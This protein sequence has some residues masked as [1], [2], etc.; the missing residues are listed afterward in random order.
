MNKLLIIL[1]AGLLCVACATTEKITDAAS[2]EWTYYDANGNKKAEA[3]FH[4]DGSRKTETLYWP[5]GNKKTR[6]YYESDGV[7]KNMEWTYWESNGNPKTFIWYNRR[8]TLQNPTGMIKVCYKHNGKPSEKCTLEKHGCNLKSNTCIATSNNKTEDTY[9][10]ADGKTKK[11]YI[12]YYTNGRPKTAI[13]YHKNGNKKAKATLY[14]NGR[15]KTAI[16]Y[17]KNGN[18]KA[19]GTFDKNGRPKTAIEYHKNGNKKIEATLYENGNPKT[20]IEYASDGVK[21]SSDYPIC[22]KD[23]ETVETCRIKKHGC[24][25]A[26]TTC[27]R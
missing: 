11:K 21:E 10:Y 2:S 7:T 15:P 17:H 9:Y 13:E 23:S 8:R 4:K 1:L 27:I 14:K 24:T 22:Y 19:K 20:A 25:S 6:V 3:T 18:K 26:S 12:T 5:N 16:A